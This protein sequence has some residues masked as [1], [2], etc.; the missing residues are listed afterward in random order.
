MNRTT[1]FTVI[2]GIT[3]VLTLGG[4]AT[5]TSPSSTMQLIKFPELNAKTEAQVGDS[6]VET[7]F[8]KITPSNA[9]VL[10]KDITH[11]STEC[12][13][14]ISAGNLALYTSDKEG[15]FYRMKDHVALTIQGTPNHTVGGV[16]FPND[17]SRPTEVFCGK[18]SSQL[19]AFRARAVH[20]GIEFKK[21]PDVE[22]WE[23]NSFKRELVYSGITQNTVSILYR[24]FDYV[25]DKY[26]NGHYARPAFNQ[27]LKYDLSQGDTI[28]FKGARF[29]IIKA[30]NTGIRYEVLKH[31]D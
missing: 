19:F 26:R 3:L 4:C 1:A 27:E 22:K 2:V 20:P 9:I 12:G 23:A 29:R 7:A 13:L 16:F 5:R 28:G 14:T 30:T 31:L 21:A 6:M 24:E 10:D 18:I 11:K 17:K 8:K 25:Y 15:V